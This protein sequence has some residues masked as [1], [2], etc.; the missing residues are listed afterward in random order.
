MS[1]CRESPVRGREGHHE[2]V[3][4]EC[5]RSLIDLRTHGGRH[6]RRLL[7]L[8]DPSPPLAGFLNVSASA[9][10]S[11]TIMLSQF[12]ALESSRALSTP[13]R[14]RNWRNKC[15]DGQAII[16]LVHVRMNHESEASFVSTP[17]QLPDPAS[18]GP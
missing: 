8:S 7:F 4:S 3:H 5:R 9:M 16:E 14:I 12:R 1:I 6:T 2:P 11:R 17:K 18:S 15:R 10:S 13:E